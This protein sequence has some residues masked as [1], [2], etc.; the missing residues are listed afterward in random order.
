MAAR[1]PPHKRGFCFGQ[2][3]PI[4]TLSLKVCQCGAP[5]IPSACTLLSRLLSCAMFKTPE[6]QNLL[7][8]ERV[9]VKT[10]EDDSVKPSERS[11]CA[12]ALVDIIQL[13]RNMRGDPNPKPVD[14]SKPS[15]KATRVRSLNHV[16]PLS[17][18]PAAPQ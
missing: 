13:K 3:H 8:A 5:L 6:Y 4:L 17:D 7:A 11:Q 1:A 16:A 15:G 12:R 10:M 14:V 18:P 2:L 9:M